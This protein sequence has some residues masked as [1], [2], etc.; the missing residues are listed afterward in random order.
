MAYPGENVCQKN[1]QKDGHGEGHD[2]SSTH[3]ARQEQ[4]RKGRSRIQIPGAVKAF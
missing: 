3:V 2:S 1:E 4:P